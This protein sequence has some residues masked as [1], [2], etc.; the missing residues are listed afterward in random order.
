MSFD[1]KSA[2]VAAII[3][4]VVFT[5]G[6][7]FL[8]K[9]ST[10]D[11]KTAVREA[12]AEELK[13]NPKL[14]IDTISAYMQDERDK[15]TR[16]SDQQVISKKA[17]IGQAENF[18][19][20][21]KADGA[22]TLVYF[23]DSNCVYCK[24]LDPMLKQVVAA[25]PDVKIIHREI[26]ILTQ[27]SRLAAHVGNMLWAVDPAVY[28]A[29][30]DKLMAHR[31]TL[32]A[33]DIENALKTVMGDEKATA[34]LDRVDNENDEVVNDANN[35]VQENGAIAT[36]AGI[37]GTPFVY[38]LQGDGLMRGAGDDALERLNDLIAKARKAK[39]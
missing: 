3:T 2:A 8:G 22:V 31:G 6:Y 13:A 29:F 36:A 10:P 32:S 5:G 37:R 26:P 18:P 4:A 35:R 28:P 39:G 23:F 30:H 19:F 15:E 27:T 24:K 38:V 9:G 16:D 11:V 34:L 12:I 1:P 14:I 33:N 7:Q 25:N 20:I 17:D 21:G